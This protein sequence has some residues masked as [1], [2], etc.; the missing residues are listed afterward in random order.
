[1]NHLDAEASLLACLMHNPRIFEEVSNIEPHHFATQVHVTLY[2]VMYKMLVKGSPVDPITL[3]I[4]L[5]KRGELEM[6][7][8]MPYLTSVMTTHYSPSNAALYASVV[9][10]AYRRSE[11]RSLCFEAVGQLDSKADPI[12]VGAVIA[13]KVGKITENRNSS[14]VSETDDLL[15]SHLD[16]MERRRVG[17]EKFLSTGMADLDAKLGG[18]FSG[19]DLVILAARPAMGKTAMALSIALNVAQT[20][21]VLMFSMEMTKAQLMDRA[22]ANLG[23][24]PVGWIR[25]PN[26]DDNFWSR[27]TTGFTAFNERKFSVDDKAGRRINEIIGM[28]KQ[29]HRRKKIGLVVIDYLGLIKGSQAHSRNLELGE[30]TKALK[31]LAKDLD[32]PVLCLAQLSRDVDKRTGQ[33]PVLS[34]LRDSGEIEADA[35]TV[36]FIHRDD[37]YNPDSMHKGSA[38]IIIA[39]QRQGETGYLGLSFQGE[40]QRFDNLAYQYQRQE[41][42]TDRGRATVKGFK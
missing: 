19:G 20:S 18:G 41:E 22:I 27:H 2:R 14:S 13:D 4:E 40:Y 37:Y 7:G 9:L 42:T 38:E 34:D 25:T 12:E 31:T 3:M 5:E 15:S 33:R 28:T 21:R 35:D 1:M 24:V 36:M 17:D 6:V 30:Y 26:D 29:A 8:G 32:V 39:K 23:R 11:M 10:D 16:L